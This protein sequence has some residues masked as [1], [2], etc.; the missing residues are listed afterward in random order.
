V[1]EIC[2][3]EGGCRTL[4]LLV[5]TGGSSIAAEIGILKM[6]GYGTL[7]SS[8]LWGGSPDPGRGSGCGCDSCFGICFVVTGRGG[9]A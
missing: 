9:C 6:T 8:D 3:G 4:G 1:K 5:G 2:V 7:G